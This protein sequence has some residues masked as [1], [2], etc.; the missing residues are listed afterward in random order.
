MNKNTFV[1]PI[2]VS[3]N[4]PSDL[5]SGG[6]VN[7]FDLY[8]AVV[9]REYKNLNHNECCDFIDRIAQHQGSDGLIRLIDCDEVP[10]EGREDFWYRPTI[11]AAVVCLHT[12]IRFP[13]CMFEPRLHTMRSAMSALTHGGLCGSGYDAEDAWLQNLEVLLQAG[14]GKLVKNAPEFC[15]EFTAMMKSAMDDLRG[16]LAEADQHQTVVLSTNGWE[17]RPIQSQIR[18]I[19]AAYD[20]DLT[21]ALFVYGTLMRGNSAN[22]RFLARA[23]YAGRCQL[24]NYALYDLGQYPAIWESKGGAVLGELYFVA[25]E[26]LPAI[27]HYEG[28]GSLYHE[29]SVRISSEEGEMDASTYVYN[30]P[31]DPDRLVPPQEQPWR[32]GAVPDE[33]WYACYGSNLLEER[34]LCYIKGG[35][36]H[37][38]G[39]PYK[40]CTDQTLPRKSATVIVKGR[41]YFARNSRTWGG[42]G[43]AFYDPAGNEDVHMRLYLIQRD[44]LCEIQA[45]EGK[46]WYN[47][48]IAITDP[49]GLGREIRTLTSSTLYAQTEPQDEYLRVIRE[50]LTECFGM[51]E[52]EANRYLNECRTPMSKGD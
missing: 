30:K 51:S 32:F 41:L 25:D 11:A 19:L 5:G 21:N 17:P 40:G 23:E 28:G 14:A 4:S 1:K 29:V 3:V 24:S 31:I 36:C 10:G 7:A 9:D 49:S 45:Q 12:Y 6:S 22:E 38:N 13:S 15:P 42:G 27:K 52:T 33:V 43:V 37:H 18:S 48:E 46:D 2:H 16:Q 8:Q 47:D 35:T 26:D 44:Q 34:F 50:G 39:K 20:R